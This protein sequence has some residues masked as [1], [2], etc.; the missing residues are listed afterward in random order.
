MWLGLP[1]EAAFV[2]RYGGVGVDEAFAR[3]RGLTAVLAHVLEGGQGQPHEAYALPLSHAWSGRAVR[4]MD[5]LPDTGSL[6]ISTLE[7]AIDGSPWDPQRLRPLFEGIVHVADLIGDEKSLSTARRML[8]TIDREAAPSKCDTF[9]VT[10]S[11]QLLTALWLI[12]H[13]GHLLEMERGLALDIEPNLETWDA[14]VRA[15]RNGSVHAIPVP[16]R[17]VREWGAPEEL[18]EEA[19]RICL[20][21]S[22]PLLPQIIDEIERVWGG[23]VG[24]DV[25]EEVARAVASVVVIR[26]IHLQGE[27]HPPPGEKGSV[28]F[29]V[30][31]GVRRVGT[32]E[33]AEV[34]RRLRAV[35]LR[36]EC[37]PLAVAAAHI[38]AAGES[39]AQ[40]AHDD[41]RSHLAEAMHSTGQYDGEQARHDH[42]AVC[43]A[44]WLWL[45]GAAPEALRRLSALEGQKARELFRDIEA[46]ESAREALREAEDEHC[47][48]GQIAT[49][50]EIAIAELLA[51]HSVRAELVSREICQHHPK[52]S[53]AW[54]T[55]ASVLVDLGRYRDAVTPA[56]KCFELGSH[57]I[58]DRALLA[59]ILGRIGRDARDEA[60]TLAVEVLKA[61]DVIA[62]VAPD[63]LAELADIVQYGGGDILHAR[64]VDDLLWLNRARNDP[65][66]EW[67]GAA[68][69]RR[70]HQFFAEDA[71]MWLARLAGEAKVAPAVLGRFVVERLDAL[72][73]WRLNLLADPRLA[74]AGEDQASVRSEGIGAAIRAAISLG[75]AEPDEALGP[76]AEWLRHL[77]AFEAGLPGE[78]LVLIRA[79]ATI[80]ARVF[81]SGEPEPR[82]I[83]LAIELFEREKVMW[84]R[85][86]AD[87]DADSE[88]FM[89]CDVAGL[90]PETRARLETLLGLAQADD[91]DD[92]RTAGWVTRW[93]ETERR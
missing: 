34:L 51:G 49:W 88:A 90:S 20:R 58:G 50:C 37:D 2:E 68:V 31:Q 23:G 64:R 79:S 59:R 21:D 4:L 54:H 46:H 63:L 91:D 65:P 83:A 48:R 13:E 82:D 36:C 73:W 19:A 14:A 60:L 72:Q 43:V 62:A 70:C 69:A 47:R 67:L 15:V 74:D 12:T 5:Q 18:T 44:Q 24:N 10:A 61:D 45:A 22:A 39:Q 85:F 76:D 26:H 75:V 25:T 84:L 3:D 78:L 55:L 93:H 57:P 41:S 28:W 53:L 56:R 87:S 33:R 6:V 27:Y 11:T 66:P 17:F 8:E 77:P 9:L 92:I 38:D 42:G 52:S 7:R 86:V 35:L 89:A 40:G 29:E 1:D 81:G 32:V 30:H 71:P 80:Q 16:I